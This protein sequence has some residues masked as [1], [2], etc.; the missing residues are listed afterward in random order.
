MII[1]DERGCVV[2]KQISCMTLIGGALNLQDIHT[3]MYMDT[4]LII[5]TYYVCMVT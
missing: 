5:Q 2:D 1:G 4:N 3:Y